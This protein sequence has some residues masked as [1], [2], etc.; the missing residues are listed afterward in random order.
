MRVLEK[1]PDIAKSI[2]FRFPMLMMD[3]AQDTSDVEMKAV[4]LLIESGLKEVMLIGDPEQA[5]FEWR[6]A[7]PQL[8]E[9]KYSQW[10]DNSLTFN[11]NWR[12]S[13]KICDFFQK[14]SSLPEHPK[15]INEDVMDFNCPPEIWGF[16]NQN[17]KDIINKF[18]KHCKNWDV[19]SDEYNIA[20][21][22]R[23]RDQAKV[24]QG[25]GKIRLNS[26]PPWQ[27]DITEWVC[28][29]KFL[30]DRKLLREAFY[31]LE[32][33]IC[34]K[35]KGQPYCSHRDLEDMVIEHGFAQWRK[36]VYNLLWVL[37][38]TDCLLGE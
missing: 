10:E 11:E 20:V 7:K 38:K 24:I 25:S 6:D 17:Y 30:F 13:Q 8:L 19:R 3:E 29:S 2:A 16:E 15:A 4:D 33:E 32:K 22:V 37:P 36:Q 34:R 1:Y 31:R 14:I 5:I 12:S 23:S 9:Q 21:L 28:Y 26:Q 18:L 35:A 27:N